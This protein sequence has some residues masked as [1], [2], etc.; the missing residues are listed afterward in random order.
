MYLKMPDTLIQLDVALCFLPSFLLLVTNDKQVP[1]PPVA[2]FKD[3]VSI[4]ALNI[5]NYSPLHRPITADYSTDLI[6]YRSRQCLLLQETLWHWN[7]SWTSY[8]LLLL[9]NSNRNKGDCINQ[10]ECHYNRSTIIRQGMK[11]NSK[12]V[13]FCLV[14]A[15]KH[16]HCFDC[17]FPGFAPFLLRARLELRWS[18]A[19]RSSGMIV[20]KRNKNTWAETCPTASLSPTYLKHVAL[21]SNL[22]LHGERMA[23]NLFAHDKAFY[24]P[25]LA[26]H[27]YWLCS[28]G[29]ENTLMLLLK[30]KRANHFVS[31]IIL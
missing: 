28:Y 1:V 27:V 16:E 6:W 13:L 25:I 4:A 22:D 8:K 3:L 5:L 17:R 15:N 26:W 12:D 18:V 31:E 24:R 21:V 10:A 11:H 14:F 7:T 9:L 2:V 30:K 23:T 19:W 29:T 20:I